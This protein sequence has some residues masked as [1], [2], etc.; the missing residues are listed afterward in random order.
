MATWTTRTRTI[1]RR[2]WVVPMYSGSTDHA[3]VLGAIHAAREARADLTPGMRGTGLSDDA[4]MVSNGDDEIVVWFETDEV[5]G[6]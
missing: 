2:E 3:Q 5:T 1:T 4:V 6:R